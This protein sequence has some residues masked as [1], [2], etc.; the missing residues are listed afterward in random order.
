M[1]FTKQVL[2]KL[3]R[4]YS[5]S[6]LLI[7]N[8]VHL[9]FSEEEIGGSCYDYYGKDF[10]DKRLVWSN[11]G[12]TMSIVPLPQRNGDFIA[13][14]A[15]F[16]GFNARQAKLVWCH[17]H[18]GVWEVHDYIAI[19]YL[20]RFDIAEFEDKRYLI[21]GIV[22]KDKKDR[23]DWSVPGCVVYAELTEN[24]NLKPKIIEMPQPIFM[25]HGYTR[26]EIDKQEGYFFSGNNGI[27]QLKYVN[28]TF[29]LTEFANM[30]VSDAAFIDIDGDGLTEMMTIEPFHGNKVRIYHQT[31]AGWEMIFEYPDDIVFAHAITSGVVKDQP[32]FIFGCRRAKME[33]V[34]ITYDQKLKRYQTSL[35][36]QGC[37]SANVL[38]FMREG[39]Q[40]LASCNHTI[41][42]AAVY[43]LS[44][45]ETK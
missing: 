32:C 30:A 39:Q 42:E 37:G 6:K 24:W 11:G 25:N 31:N 40:W 27:F 5:V 26:A 29:Q 44:M 35:I 45:E 18:H 14:Q 3:E 1:S 4:C 16:P 43:R 19:P 15:F 41:N 10:Q 33:L 7:D 38:L 23:D 9:I 17:L 12:G 28:Q 20:H 2:D 36:D 13:V 8:E 22:S 34:M 21:G